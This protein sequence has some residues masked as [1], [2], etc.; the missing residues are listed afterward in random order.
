LLVGDGATRFARTL[1]MDPY[2]PTTPASREKSR[3]VQAEL[4]HPD[5]TLEADWRHFD[6]RARWNFERSLA[7]S[8]LSAEDAGTDTV[9]VAVRAPAGRSALALSTGGTAIS[10][11]GRVGD[12]PILG[13]GLFA[14]KHG[15]AAATGAGERIHEAGLARAIH[16]WLSAGRTPAQAAQRGVE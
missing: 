3:A 11:R 2:D 13:A 1:G 9:G 7:A 4:L 12:V 5:T 10:M 8:G 16:G 6:W 15:A 14:G